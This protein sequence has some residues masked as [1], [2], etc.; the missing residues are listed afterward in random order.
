M[1]FNLSAWHGFSLAQFETASALP[2]HE[3]KDSLPKS[4]GSREDD[5]C[6]TNTDAF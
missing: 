6:K 1:R 4:V 2:S 5:E 3:H